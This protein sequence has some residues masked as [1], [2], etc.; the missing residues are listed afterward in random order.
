MPLSQKLDVKSTNKGS[1]PYRVTIHI[2]EGE[3]KFTEGSMNIFSGSMKYVCQEMT[4]SSQL[5]MNKSSQ[6]PKQ[7]L[8]S[9]RLLLVILN[10]CKSSQHLHKLTTYSLRKIVSL[11]GV[12]CNFQLSPNLKCIDSIVIEN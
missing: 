3:N 8:F 6:N 5:M 9:F 12:E 11:K 2:L 1:L 10:T 4:R 7:M